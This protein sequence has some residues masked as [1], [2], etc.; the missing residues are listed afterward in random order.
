MRGTPSHKFVKGRI[1]GE[2][3]EISGYFIEFRVVDVMI[4]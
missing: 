4:Q 1:I 3:V 2:P